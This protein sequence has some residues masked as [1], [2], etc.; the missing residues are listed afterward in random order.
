MKS[1]SIEVVSEAE[2]MEL[3][4]ENNWECLGFTE[5]NYGLTMDYCDN[6]PV[7]LEDIVETSNTES[8]GYVV[9]ATVSG[10]KFHIPSEGM[11]PYSRGGAKV[12][13]SYEEASKLAEKL[14]ARGEKY[15][16]HVEAIVK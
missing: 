6:K 16:W 5:S 1:D 15:D 4:K 2:G 3:C 14:R 9:C 10:G 12:F 13:D 11:S 8:K 7:K